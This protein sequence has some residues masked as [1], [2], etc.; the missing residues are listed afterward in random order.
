MAPKE[1]Y[2]VHSLNK[3]VEDTKKGLSG[4]AQYNRRPIAK[5]AAAAVKNEPGA[6]DAAVFGN[7][8]D[9]DES[10][11]SSESDSDSDGDTGADLLKKLGANGATPKT[12]PKQRGKVDEI[13]D[14]DIERTASAKRAA[15]AK[16]GQLAKKESSTSETSSDSSSES[17]S[18]QSEPKAKKAKGTVATPQAAAAEES[19]SSSS[20]DESEEES[21]D[22]EAEP[23][24]EPKPAAKQSATAAT[25]AATN[26]TAKAAAATADSSSSSEESS[27]DEAE[28]AKPQPTKAQSTKAQSTKAQSTKAQAT[29]AQ[30]A[31]ATPAKAQP[32]KEAAEESSSDSE[33]SAAQVDESMGLSDRET[34]TQ[35]ATPNFIAPDFVLRKG[36]DGANGQ[37]VARICNEA[38]LQGKQF[39][40][41][42]VPSNVPVSVIENIEIPMDRS[43]LGNRVFSHDG[44]DYGVSFD[45]ISTKSSI[46]ILIPSSSDSNY[47]PA[48]QQVAQTMHIKRIANLGGAAATTVGPAPRRAAR[49]QPKG[50]KAR[51]QPFGVNTPMGNI[52]ADASGDEDVEMEEAPAAVATPKPA[53]KDKKS[54]KDDAKPSESKDKKKDADVAA[55]PKAAD[56]KT[57]KTDR[58]GKR[59]HTTSEDDALAAEA[60]LKEDISS[61]AKGKSKK[62]K[63]ARA[64]SPELGAELPPLPKKQTP[65]APPT[66]PSSSAYSFS[67]IPSSATA[68]ATPSK[69][70]AATP[71]TVKKSAKK[72]KPETPVPAPRQTAV[73]LPSIP[74]SARPK[75]S[76]VPLPPVAALAATP[77][78]SKSKKIKASKDEVNATSSSQQSPPP[79]AQGGDKKKA[80]VKVKGSG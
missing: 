41:F 70:P 30:T 49:P 66:I 12:G 39:W 77:V 47:Q 73:P 37:D 65:I 13:A 42:T 34:E 46:Q 31:K 4:A 48:R 3:H 11:D 14:S 10:S 24:A 35:L 17:E 9:S 53:K 38:N 59:K 16:Q 74:L 27:E 18:E 45:T 33:D 55:T 22:E 64:S 40:Y 72:T 69:A 44:Q 25:P 23:E 28:P 8:N 68:V 32:A 15:A 2:K 79:S 36:D 43:Q 1:P 20:E 75:E 56:V 54:K 63:T 80:A 67:N 78:Q 62:Q 21:D 58:K 51:Y 29:K 71:S 76:P 57:P 52:G 26:G 61:S 6:L 7:N 60:Q 50:L 19:S 5:A